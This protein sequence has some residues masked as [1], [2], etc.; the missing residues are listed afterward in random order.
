MAL[1]TDYD[2]GVD[3][4]E[5]VTMDQVFAVMRANVA[6]VREIL[7]DLVTSDFDSLV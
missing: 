3:G 4:H 6:R 7:V 5:P 2:A 1:V